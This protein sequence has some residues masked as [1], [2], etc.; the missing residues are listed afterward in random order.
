MPDKRRWRSPEDLERINSYRKHTDL[1]SGEHLKKSRDGVDVGVFN[2]PFGKKGR[3]E[4]IPYRIFNLLGKGSE[5][6]ANIIVGDEVKITTTDKTVQTWLD[7]L[8]FGLPLW[9]AVTRT[10]YKGF[11]GLQPIP[12]QD[13]PEDTP[14]GFDNSKP[15]WGWSVIDP[16][17]LYIEFHPANNEIMSIRKAVP[18]RKVKR[19]TKEIDVLYEEKHY[20]D[21][22]EFYLY[23]IS[24]EFIE[25]ELALEEYTELIDKNAKIEPVFQHNLGDFMISILFNKRVR[26]QI[27]SDYTKPAIATQESLN[28]VDTQ[29]ARILKIHSD[30]KLLVPR[31]AFTKN[32]ATGESSIDLE[33][34][35]AIA[36]D[37]QTPARAWG[38]LTWDG[39]L[40]E[41]RIDKEHLICVLLTEFDMAPHF[42]SYPPLM[43]ST[44]AETAA[45]L[46]KLS[47]ATVK[48]AKRKTAW[49]KKALRS[50]VRNILKLNEQYQNQELAHAKFSIETPEI[51]TQSRDEIISEAVVRKQNGLISSRSAIAKIDKITE[52][53]AQKEVDQ[54]H[55]EVNNE[56]QNPYNAGLLDQIGQA[57]N[58]FGVYNGT[59]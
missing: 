56:T 26:H 45:K 44:S 24:G 52:E 54:I 36:V 10:S 47:H 31:S 19:G 28:S 18:F 8:D 38:Y 25:K 34:N 7:A 12:M 29:I 23:E 41:A 57:R 9:E 22:V 4:G 37:N 5:A 3:E 13:P 46:E 33:D 17:H 51:I 14:E 50:L 49:L 21:R 43:N 1:Y 58:E 48:R 20:K 16:E 59:I 11:C 53:E 55:N 2:H 27:I 40:N 39:Q 15:F 35:E 6:F 30:P 42:I 32:E